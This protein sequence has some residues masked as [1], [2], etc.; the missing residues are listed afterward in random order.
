[1]AL[2]PDGELA[3]TLDTVR[4]DDTMIS[5]DGLVF[6]VIENPLPDGFQGSTLDVSETPDGISIVFSS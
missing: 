2:V 6:L 1:L 3:L 5:Q 4:E